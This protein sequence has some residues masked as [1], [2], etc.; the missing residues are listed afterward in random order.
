[1]KPFCD[2]NARHERY[3]RTY[4]AAAVVMMVGRGGGRRAAYFRR[5]VPPDL[6][7]DNGKKKRGRK[8]IRRY[9]SRLVNGMVKKKKPISDEYQARYDNVPNKYDT[10]IHDAASSAT[11]VVVV[12]CVGND[13]RIGNRY[14]WEEK[15]E[16]FSRQE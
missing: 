14:R 1:M 4:T 7:N 11:L 2:K 12:V 6:R 13:Q 16:I 15:A 10:H 5:C 8:K 3:V 9:S